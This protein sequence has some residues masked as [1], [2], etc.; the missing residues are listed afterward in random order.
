MILNAKTVAALKLD[1][2]TDLIVFD[3]TLPGFG[4]RLRLSHDG[5]RVL[6]SWVVQYKRAGRTSRMTLGSVEV[7]SAEQARIAA[8]KMLAKVALG[9]DPA[10]D[11]RERRDRDRLSLRAVID[12]YLAAKQR[13]VRERTFHQVTRYLTAGYFRPLH[14]IPVD[15]VSRKDVASR[16]IAITREHGSIVASRARAAFSTLFVWCLQ[17]GLIESNPVIGTPKPKDGKPRDRVL[18]DSELAAIWRACGDGDFGKI[19]KL[20][21]LLG[22]RRAEIG[23]MRWSE[24]ND[25]RQPTAWTLPAERS[26]NGKAH[27][28]PIMPM[29]AEIISTVPKLVGRDLLFGARSDGGFTTWDD[30]KQAL[31]GRSG[32]TGW[33]LHDVRRSVATKMA[34]IGVQP[35][36]IEEILAH[37]SGH[38]AGV[39][40]IYNRSRYT[41]EV[42]NALALWEDHLRS[43]I[44]GG[45]RKVVPIAHPTA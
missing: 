19:V 44:E 10:L 1:G 31:D 11:R 43:L 21:I 30:E 4:H 36:I 6:R 9:E 41:T 22:C 17:S 25:P 29:V 27:T 2:K 38:R 39:A 34:D 32:V 42:R 12:E 35:H 37:T 40:G 20:L 33:K 45:E 3:E 23:G 8:K 28:L 13:E 15:Q 18:S 7:L 26:K 5:K 24:F 16:L 14:G